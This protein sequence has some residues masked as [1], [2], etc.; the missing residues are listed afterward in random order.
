[1]LHI[2]SSEWPVHLPKLLGMPVAAVMPIRS[3]RGG[4]DRLADELSDE[5]RHRLSLAM[6]SRLVEKAEAAL[7]LPLVVSADEGV[8][9]WAT[10]TGL[11]SLP[12]T[13]RGLDNAAA[14]GARWAMDSGLQGVILH[15][16]LPLIDVGELQAVESLARNGEAVLAPSADGG[17]SALGSPT[18]IE[19]SYGVASAHRHLARLHEP[20]ILTTTGLLHD[21]DTVRDL[22]S[23]MRHPAGQW[24]RDI[25]T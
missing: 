21:V 2:P 8:L 19:F 6:A 13:G 4:K 16:D 17:T 20:H 14:E 22:R 12:E 11:A 15:S 5:V 7:L 24:I 3:F 9:E 10:T 23:A 1:M 18:A 25:L